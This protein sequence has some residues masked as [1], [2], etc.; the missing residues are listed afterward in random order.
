VDKVSLV[1][2]LSLRKPPTVS[3]PFG[4]PHLLFIFSA[5][6]NSYKN[7]LYSIFVIFKQLQAFSEKRNKHSA[8]TNVGKKVG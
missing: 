2:A 3:K 1:L 7:M 5:L 6:Q 4:F 8:F